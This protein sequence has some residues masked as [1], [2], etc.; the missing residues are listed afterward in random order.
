MHVWWAMLTSICIYFWLRGSKWHTACILHAVWVVPHQGPAQ[1]T[2]FPKSWY[3]WL[4]MQGLFV[5]TLL[6]GCW[7]QTEAAG[8]GPTPIRGR[9]GGGGGVAPSLPLSARL[10]PGLAFPS[11]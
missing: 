4:E 5:N 3:W 10:M 11:H 8:A 1:G 2:R 6:V 9:E 7:G